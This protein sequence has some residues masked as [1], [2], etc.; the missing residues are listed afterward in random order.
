[1]HFAGMLLLSSIE[2]LASVLRQN[3]KL[4]WLDFSSNKLSHNYTVLEI[5][6]PALG[7]CSNLETLD[8]SHNGIS[9]KN[10]SSLQHL[11]IKS[12]SLKKLS[13]AQNL[14]TLESILTLDLED[15]WDLFFKSSNFQKFNKQSFGVA[16]TNGNKNRGFQKSYNSAEE[17]NNE[18]S[19]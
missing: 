18:G 2:E 5:L 11:L 10:R 17:K 4:Q 3:N 15:Q 12:K 19:K 16:T 7:K 1:M 14:I 9:H 13:L 8:L 6:L